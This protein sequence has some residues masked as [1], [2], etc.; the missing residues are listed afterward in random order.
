MRTTRDFA[1]G[2]YALVNS[3]FDDRTEETWTTFGAVVARIVHRGF[4]WLA[5]FHEVCWV[6]TEAVQTEARRNVIL[7]HTERIRTT[8]QFAATIDALSSAFANLEANLLGFAIE[9]VRAMVALLTSS[10]EIVGIT[11]VTG[12]ADAN[13]FLADGSRTTFD[14]AALVDA[15]AAD[16]REIQRTRKIVGARACRGISAGTDLHLLTAEERI[17]EEAFSAAAVVATDGVDTNGV[18][19]AGVSVAFVDI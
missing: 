3:R 17:A 8:L 19:A 15:F 10:S 14:L 13:A 9:I 18:V 6:S 12:W 11:V 2:V 5:A 16:A 4:M 1:A 7:R